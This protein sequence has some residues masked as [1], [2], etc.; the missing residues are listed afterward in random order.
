MKFLA[1]NNEI[2][3]KMYKNFK[4]YY[5]SYTNESDKKIS[6]DVIIID[7]LPVKKFE[8]YLF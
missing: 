4:S 6:I 1:E 5:D 2:I 8:P 3:L 7:N